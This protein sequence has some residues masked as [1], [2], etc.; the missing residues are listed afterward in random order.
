MTETDVLIGDTIA[1]RYRLESLLGVGAMGSVFRARHVVIDRIA[2]IKILNS[3]LLDHG[4]SR[5]WFVREARAVNRVNHANIAEIHDLGE[6]DDGRVYLVMELLEGIRL[7]DHIAEGPMDLALVLS[8]VEQIA[9]ALARAHGLGVVHRDLKPEHVF[10]IERGGRRDFVKLIDFGLARLMNEGRLSA[11]GAIFG[12]PAYMSPEQSSGQDAGPQADLYALGVV[13]FEMLTGQP[14]FSSD[15]PNELLECHR[16]AAPPDPTEFRGGLDPAF[17]HMVLKLLAKNLDHR[18]RDAHHVVDDCKALQHRS[19]PGEQLLQVQLEPHPAPDASAV[20]IDGVAAVALKASLFGRMAAVLYPRGNGPRSVVDGV[21][22]LWSLTA[23]LSRI[24]GELEIISRW[25]EN[26]RQRSREFVAEAGR[27]IDELARSR[28][29]TDRTLV[30]TRRQLD[31]VNLFMDSSRGE[32]EASRV[33]I[34]TIKKAGDGGQLNAALQ[35]A[36]SA[37]AKVQHY[38]EAAAALDAKMERWFQGQE[39]LDR[40]IE[41]FRRELDHHSTRIDADL[42]RG[43]PRL[44]ALGRE[45]EDCLKKIDRTTAA[46]HLAFAHRP[47]CKHLMAEMNRL[48]PAHDHAGD[49][50]GRIPEPFCEP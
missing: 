11:H 49:H 45:R 16:S 29:E 10:L 37:A 8:V 2:A 7:I 34:D 46:L 27:K 26:L 43:K 41:R 22:S 35:S 13:L 31:Q 32:R 42:E 20:R 24:E 36:A 17:S 39:N 28:S 18:Y 38:H 14:P 9:S 23:D 25:D 1:G 47:A 33:L 6:T 21:E 30:E 19:H 3:N 12:T 5:A 15:D 44:S 40:Q 50:P 48:F 4:S